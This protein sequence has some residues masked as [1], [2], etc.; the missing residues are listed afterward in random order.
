M[1]LGDIRGEVIL[2]ATISE[3]QLQQ[4]E[5]IESLA[6]LRGLQMCSHLGIQHLI[7]ESD[8]QVVVNELRGAAPS[9]YSL[10]N[11]F[12]DIQAFMATFQLCEI[13][14]YYR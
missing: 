2:A 12:L 1:I 8:C 11:I 9:F 3:N 7:L 6:I 13:S 14:F 10:G 5:S 4:L